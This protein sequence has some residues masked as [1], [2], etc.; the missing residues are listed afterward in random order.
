LRDRSLGCHDATVTMRLL[1]LS[2][3]LAVGCAAPLA[4]NQPGRVVPQGD[5]RLGGA[6]GLG[7]STS[8]LD[9]ITVA[10]DAQESFSAAIVSDGCRLDD[11]SL[12]DCV[13]LDEYEPLIRA[14]LI[15]LVA[16]PVV[17]YWAIEARFGLLDRVD[18]GGRYTGGTFGLD[19]AFQLF[20]PTDGSP[21]AS[22]TVGLG[23]NHHSVSL[24][25]P[26][27]AEKLKLEEFEREDIDVPLLFG[28]KVGDWAYLTAGVRYMASRWRIDLRPG[29][30]AWA[31]TAA[32]LA[33]G[34][35][36]DDAVERVIIDALPETDEEGWVHQLGGVLGAYVGYKY[37]YVGAELT[38][39]GYLFEATILGTRQ[40]LNGLTLFPTV[41]GFL[42]F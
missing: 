36:D 42:Q 11:G 33:G 24:P 19:A 1:S 17:P 7:I 9:L 30:P 25:L 35:V 15:G 34:Q 38:L 13:P 39:T 3:A 4:V 31:K 32:E 23:W 26:S 18:L 12:V 8:A 22:A 14:G 40:E 20:G 29:I 41:S 37:A 28:Y 2:A 6:V 27:A 21:G 10:E 5:V 16:T